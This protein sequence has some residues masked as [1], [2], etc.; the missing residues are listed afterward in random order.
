MQQVRMDVFREQ[1]EL[2]G[3]LKRQFRSQEEE[4]YRLM[5]EI[6]ELG[7]LIGRHKNDAR[8]YEEETTRNYSKK[9]E[10]DKV[11][12]DYQKREAEGAKALSELKDQLGK[13][14]ET[15]AEIQCQIELENL[16]VE[17]LK[18]ELR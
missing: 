5:E 18:G 16:E 13:A 9:Q 14:T 17:V 3:G 8:Y 10:Y 12:K 7:D 2:E 6:H 11:T 15:Q 1:E 4:K